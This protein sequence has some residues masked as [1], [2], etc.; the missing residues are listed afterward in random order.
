MKRFPLLVC[1]V[2]LLLLFVV[3]IP[4]AAVVTISRVSP[5]SGPNNGDVSVTITG[6]GFNKDTT[7]WMS[8]CTTGGLVPGTVVKWSNTSLT[9]RFSFNGQKPAKY[10]VKVDSPFTD[11]LGNY[12]PQDVVMLSQS[13]SV[14]QG[15]GTTTVATTLPG[16]TDVTTTIT[17]AAT[18]GAGANSVFFETNPSGAEIWLSDEDVG[19]S[20][21]TYYTDRDGTF[22]VVAKKTGY[23]DYEDRV[24]ILSGQRVHFY[25]SLTPLSSTSNNVTTN[26]TSSA[27]SSSAPVK[28][29]TTIRR[30]T[31][32]IPTPL[33]TD[34][35]VTEESPADPALA[36]GAAGIVIGLVLLRRR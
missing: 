18:S 5:E 13:F 22:D 24:T 33:G 21:F 35:P 23:E 29:N 4:A 20:T 10:D 15:T 26:A 9:C 6:S 17:T 8:S 11:P 25:G 19:T 30:S 14:Y 34:P 16:T 12:Y 27:S 7:V 1:L 28:T 36:L 2:L 32:K 3:G 31:L